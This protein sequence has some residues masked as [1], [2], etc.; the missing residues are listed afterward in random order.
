MSAAGRPGVGREHYAFWRAA[1]CRQ[2]HLLE[3]EGT[4]HPEDSQYVSD[5]GQFGTVRGWQGHEE[6]LN[7]IPLVSKLFPEEFLEE[8]LPCSK[9]LHVQ[10]RYSRSA[11]REGTFYRNS[12]E[13][14]KQT[15]LHTR[16]INHVLKQLD[17]R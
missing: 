10:L 11:L 5:P 2:W 17:P 6:Q 8:F 14:N 12:Q 1:S 3:Y 16:S 7:T 13:K 9:L 4:Q 15:K